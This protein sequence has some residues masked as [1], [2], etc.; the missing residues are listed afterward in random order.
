MIWTLVGH[1]VTRRAGRVR[2]HD[3]PTPEA[4]VLRLLSRSRS[5]L[6]AIGDDKRDAR[7][8][9]LATARASTRRYNLTHTR[10]CRECATMR[11]ALRL[12]GG[13]GQPTRSVCTSGGHSKD[14]LAR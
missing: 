1:V 4:M 2:T 6:P 5:A 8:E 9:I 12:T 3:V 14:S 11:D 7:L 10:E 13:L